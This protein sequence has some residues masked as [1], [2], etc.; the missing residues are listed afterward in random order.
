LGGYGLLASLDA[1]TINYLATRNGSENTLPPD[2][3]QTVG[4][5]L[6]ASP[7]ALE[8]LGV[9]GA[10]QLRE[11]Q[12]MAAEQGG[13]DAASGRAGRYRTGHGDPRRAAAA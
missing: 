1:D 4:T 9:E 13:S 10:E 3:R 6:S 7:E 2:W 5:A 8:A 11:L 12:E